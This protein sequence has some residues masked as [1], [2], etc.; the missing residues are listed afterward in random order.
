MKK[1]ILA[2][3]LAGATF[4]TGCGDSNSFDGVSGQQ[5]N[6]QPIVTPTTTPTPTTG[7]FVDATNGNDTTGNVNTG[8]PYATIQAAVT[9]APVD[10]VIFVRGGT[11]AGDIALKNGQELLGI[12]TGTKPVLSGVLTL[13]DGNAVD[14]LKFQG[15][16]GS[17][18]DGTDQSGGTITNCEFEDTTNIGSAIQAFSATGTWTIEGNTM[19][20]L[21]G[22]GVEITAGSGD[23]AVLQINGNMITDSDF[24]AIGL[25]VFDNG[26]MRAQI[27]DNI[28]TGNQPTVTVEVL[29]SN[30]ADFV[31]QIVGNT[32]DDTYRL[33]L[34]DSP[35]AK[36]RVERLGQ[37]TTLNDGAA[38]VLV[39]G[40]AP[41]DVANG[42]AGFGTAP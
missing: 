31:A 5:G 16:N 6:P 41:E 42:A 39:D 1:T 3:L 11:Y 14:F 32:N 18:I 13:G 38:T 7:Y 25:Q 17:S 10:A 26:T 19:N 40:D 28:M 24:N 33:S 2:L 15:T 27:T 37:L 35:A 8:A 12:V 36:L 34:L 9:A 23:A 21:S 22:A 30:T 20:N 4:V 29:V